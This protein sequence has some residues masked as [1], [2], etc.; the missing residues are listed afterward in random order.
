MSFRDVSATE[1]LYILPDPKLTTDAL[2]PYLSDA[3]WCD[4]MFG[5][6]CSS[7]LRELAPGLA[8]FVARPRSKMRLTMSPFLLPEDRA[9]IE[10]GEREPT[11]KIL[12]ALMREYGSTQIDAPALTLHTLR[13]LAY[14]IASNRLEMKI[15]LV[16]DGLFNPKVWLLNDGQDR[17]AIHGSYNLTGSGLVRNVEQVYVSRAWVGTES[18]AV[19]QKL[20][21][22]F[23]SLWSEHPP[24]GIRV[25]ALPDAIRE[26]IIREYGRDQ[27]PRPEDY[28]S[29][30][31][32]DEAKPRR[33]TTQ[34]VQVTQAIRNQFEIP[35]SIVYE[36]G[37]FGYQGAA[38]KAWE[39]NGRRG[40]LAMA[41]G[42]G[43]TITSLI[44]A[45]RA[46]EAAPGGLLIVV[47]APYLPLVHQWGREAARFGLAPILPTLA[48]DRAAKLSQVSGAV[49]SV[50]YRASRCE[51]LVVTH[52]LLGD[53]AFLE[54][55]AHTSAV[56]M[57]VADEVHNLG[58]RHFLG[59]P[60]DFFEFR[61]GLSAT[62]ER[63]YDPEGSAG[64]ETFFG[65]VVFEFT[66][67]QAIGKCLVPYDYH[68]HPVPLTSDEFEKWNDLSKQIA[69][70]GHQLNSTESNELDPRLKALLRE[71]RKLVEQAELKVPV[72]RSA[73]S[74]EDLGAL[75]HTLV[76]A[77]DKGRDQLRA[78]NTILMDQ[79]HLKIHQLT[80]E[81]TGD[82]RLAGDL[83]AN[84]ARGDGIQVLTA[85]RVL[86][87]GIDI[88]EIE[89]AYIV[90]STTVERQWVQRRGRVLRKCD[91]IGKQKATLH[92]FI[93]V[94][95]DEASAEGVRNS[96]QSLLKGELTRAMEFA[97]LS[98][99]AGASGGPVETLTSL[100]LK[101][102]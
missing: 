12:E 89:K 43:K 81:E 40:I 8:E 28:A 95:P 79:L 20:E 38:V 93:A 32:S 66:L 86:D 15:V 70:A 11:E 77:S 13:C 25:Y 36:K 57:L 30:F 33:P 52:D 73:I 3:V 22:Y 91:R 48:A 94:P 85:M 67:A 96:I 78:I 60:P 88:P 18:E 42:S 21:R 64:L 71:R 90:A 83:L 72:F 75:R 74:Q 51:C 80:H 16:Q 39:V 34:D 82:G 55:I 65:K 49:R 50:S 4:C 35:S 7:A 84:F 62:P 61:L 2:V 26:R 87:E 23:L 27:P 44:A 45:R 14:L 98:N 17:V 58:T 68:V 92:D 54:A 99:N 59:K 10:A 29:A 69:V 63:Q 76:Y 102:F 31:A 97:K 37:D 19:I 101:Y 56:R 6:F 47:A 41:T 9:A 24:Q 100:Y 5:F 1:S 46:L 53:P